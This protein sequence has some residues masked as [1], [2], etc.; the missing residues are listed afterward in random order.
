MNIAFNFRK[1]FNFGMWENKINIFPI[2]PKIID[3][4]LDNIMIDWNKIIN[5]LMI[6]IHKNTNNNDIL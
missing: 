5:F 6:F 3:T 1:L 4:I 2:F